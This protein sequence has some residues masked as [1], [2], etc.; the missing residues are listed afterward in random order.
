M[1]PPQPRTIV[2]RAAT[3][4]DLPAAV[5]VYR[6]SDP[7]R[8]GETDGSPEAATTDRAVLDD[9]MMLHVSAAA[10]VWI[11]ETPEGITGIA[12]A[13]IR[14]PHWHLA[15]LF[16]EPRWQG[17]GIGRR[18]LDACHGA[19]IEAGCDRFSTEPS[20]DPRA[21]SSYLRLG[22]LPAAP[23]LG[24]EIAAS[25]LEVSVT[26][27]GL[28]ERTVGAGDASGLAAIDGIDRVVRGAQRPQ[29]HRAWLEQ[30]GVLVLLEDAA[31]GAP[32]GYASTRMLDGFR[33]IGP[34][35]A[36]DVRQFPA[37][38]V[39][40]LALARQQSGPATRLKAIV[41]AG[42]IAALQRLPE[43]GFRPT[44]LLPLMQN[45]PIGQWDRYLF[46]DFDVL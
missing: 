30:D 15:Y 1:P 10:A 2:I 20:P 11:A 37:I 12:A 38:L 34:V 36:L 8:A 4:G 19:G 28:L 17:L 21:L 29:D 41:P 3:A 27:D 5:P 40:A 24:F 7:D 39:R 16:V 26:P 22:M 46:A 42:N 44:L 31:S 33:R 18:L 35:A 43:A 45:G 13:A 6:H 32:A 14:P 23:A 25:A 9:L